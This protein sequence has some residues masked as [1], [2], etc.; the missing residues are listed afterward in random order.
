MDSISAGSLVTPGDFLGH[1]Q[2]FEICGGCYVDNTGAIRATLMGKVV[3]ED[4]DGTRK[5]GV[6]S[7]KQ[8]AT[9]MVIDVGDKVLCRVVRLSM[10]QANVDILAVGD[11]ILPESAKGIIRREDVRLSEIDKIIMHECFRPGD[12][13]IGGVIS[14]G[15]S[16]QYYISTADVDLGVRWARSQETGNILNPISWKVRPSIHLLMTPETITPNCQS[17]SCCC[18]II[19]RHYLLLL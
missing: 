4:K 3:I 2:T 15:D 17:C 10:N 9:E 14:L 8:V 18:L 6:V 7:N 11:M 1:S 12:L 19:F 13:V 16:R 5:I